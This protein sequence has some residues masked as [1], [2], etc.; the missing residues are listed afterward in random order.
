MTELASAKHRYRLPETGTFGVT[1]T[2]DELTVGTKDD[3]YCW[4]FEFDVPVEVHSDE[5]V[6]ITEDRTVRLHQMAYGK[7][8]TKRE[9][10]GTWKA[11]KA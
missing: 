7:V 9:L 10:H 6:E 5:W 8:K 3:K 2:L 4:R 1:G 11:V